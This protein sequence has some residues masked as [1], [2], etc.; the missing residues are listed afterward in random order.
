MLRPVA[1]LGHAATAAAALPRRWAAAP[2][3]AEA[4]PA[5]SGRGTAS[6]VDSSAGGSG[7]SSPYEAL[8][9]QQ[10]AT[11]G[12]VR[13]AYI[14]LAREVH[15]DRAGGDAAARG[16]LEERFKEV[17]AA[18]F[19]LGDAA[20]RREYDEH[21]TLAAPSAA[22]SPMMW[23]R[24]QRARAE[25]GVLMPNWGSEEPPRWLIFVGPFSVLT[26]AGVFSARHDILNFSK[27]QRILRSG[28]WACHDCVIV[29]GPGVRHCRV[30]GAERYEI[31]LLPK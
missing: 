31:A 21:G 17:Q 8:G 25:D 7:T 23:A 24:L 2:A 28:G 26:L 27:D 6:A 4:A 29:N 5:G 9:V 22:W 16:R 18:W 11:D 14:R 19:V 20:R 10:A 30:C 15:P 1:R 3:G 12:E 13:K